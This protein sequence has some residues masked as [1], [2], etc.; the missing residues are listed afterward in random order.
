MGICGG[1]EEK[2]VADVANKAAI[3]ILLGKAPVSSAPEEG[4]PAGGSEVILCHCGRT[5]FVPHHLAGYSPA[6]FPTGAAAGGMEGS[7]RRDKVVPGW[8][9]R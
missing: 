2:R 6:A 9:A 1:W 5:K 4:H 7:N 3:C 8:A